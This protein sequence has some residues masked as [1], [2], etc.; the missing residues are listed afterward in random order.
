MPSGWAIFSRQGIHWSMPANPVMNETASGTNY[1]RNAIKADGSLD[2]CGTFNV[3]ITKPLDEP[4]TLE[5]ME[6]VVANSFAKRGWTVTRTTSLSSP[7]VGFEADFHG[8]SAGCDEVGHIQEFLYRDA[9]VTAMYAGDVGSDG[10]YFLE[11][12]SL[13]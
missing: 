3:A 10:P 8:T 11:S 9:V 13:D 4:P 7:Q 12:F 2:P 1:G 6:S 5:E